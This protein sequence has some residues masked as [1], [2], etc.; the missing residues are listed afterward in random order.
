MENNQNHVFNTAENSLCYDTNTRYSDKIILIESQCLLHP[1][2]V[3]AVLITIISSQQPSISQPLARQRGRLWDLKV[4]NITKPL[5]GYH[6]GAPP[7]RKD[8][9]GNDLAFISV[10]MDICVGQILF[11]V[12]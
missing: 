9:P 7:W 8:Q 3:K 10:Y 5:P 11:S 6:K 4:L 1:Q 2:P 12:I